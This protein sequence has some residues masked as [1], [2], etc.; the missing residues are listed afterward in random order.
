M[1]KLLYIFIIAFPISYLF[2]QEEVASISTDA[3]GLINMGDIINYS[4][5]NTND[6][7]IATL[8]TVNGK[9]NVHLMNSELNEIEEPLSRS[10]NNGGLNNLVGHK[11][12]GRIY[13]FIYSDNVRNALAIFSFDFNSRETKKTKVKL[14]YSGERIVEAFSSFNNRFL[15]FYGTKDNEI[16]LRELNEN[17]DKLIEIGRF[18]VEDLTVGKDKIRFKNHF[19]Y[20]KARYTSFTDKIPTYIY[21]VQST[22]KKYQSKDYIIFTVENKELGTSIYEIKMDASPSLNTYFVPYPKARIKSYATHNSFVSGNLLFQIAV[23]L[24]E[25]AWRV[26]DF[27]GNI[28]KE[29]YV[30][31][32]DE[33]F[34]T[35]TV[36]KQKGATALPFQNKREFDK[37]SKFLRKVSEGTVGIF[38]Q[39][40]EKGYEI[41][42][43]GTRDNVLAILLN[44][45]TSAAAV[46]N[47]AF[48]N[49]EKVIK[50][51]GL[52]DRNFNHQEGDLEMNL[53]DRIAEFQDD[54]KRDFNYNVFHYKGAIYYSYVDKKGDCIRY[55]RF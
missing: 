14:S 48:V 47:V 19:L 20:S 54:L 39:T 36:M 4:A 34:F 53:V 41:T 11:I 40:N 6:Q 8:L 7:E 5:S 21:R 1:R 50:F 24:R 12:D 17:N 44:S 35:N 52:F 45:A 46:Q 27:E 43:G 18:P 2:S 25:M 28:K 9:M 29:Y 32:D 30:T 42:F 26:T 37:T 55:I 3:L 51:T 23:D 10:L 31:K 38:A 33:I 15:I 13:S 22:Y 16:V 49:S